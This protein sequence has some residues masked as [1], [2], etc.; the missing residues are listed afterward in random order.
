LILDL[1]EASDL[2]GIYVFTMVAVSAGMERCEDGLL[3]LYKVHVASTD[4][5]TDRGKRFGGPALMAK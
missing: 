1:R 5:G 4:V 2:H 3:V